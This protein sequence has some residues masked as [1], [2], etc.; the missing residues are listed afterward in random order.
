MIPLK[1]AGFFGDEFSDDGQPLR[2]MA[3]TNPA[4]NERD[5]VVYLRSA[6]LL[7]VTP[8]E[9]YDALDPEMSIEG[10]ETRTDG[11]WMWPRQF[12]HYVEKYHFP[13]PDE[14]VEHM[15]ARD[16]KPPADSEIDYETILKDIDGK[17]VID[18]IID[19]EGDTKR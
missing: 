3:R 7:F 15:R 5:I 16:W 18:E 17:E 2:G 12:A 6:P 8:E 14:F 1:K 9:T 11:V 13:V 19:A 10:G 4:P